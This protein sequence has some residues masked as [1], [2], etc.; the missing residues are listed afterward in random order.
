MWQY[1]CLVV[2]YEASE[3]T[4]CAQINGERVVGLATCLNVYGA[5][6][7]EL[8]SVVPTNIGSPAAES[9]TATFKKQASAVESTLGGS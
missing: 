7:W 2:H 4:Y 9:L 5:K 8:V 1:S 3:R 6:G